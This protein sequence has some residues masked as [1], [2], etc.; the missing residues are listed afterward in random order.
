V[1]VAVEAGRPVGVAIDRRGM[2]GGSVRQ[3]AGPWRVS[4]GWWEP[5]RWNR[6]EWDVALGDGSVCRLVR[7]RE[8]GKWFVEGVFD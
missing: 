3:A 2:P 4:G 5:E 1:R 8:T 6:D 7:D